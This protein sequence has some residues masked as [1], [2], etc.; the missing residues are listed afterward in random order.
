MEFTALSETLAVNSS[1]LELLLT[2]QLHPEDDVQVFIACSVVP[3][4]NVAGRGAV[5]TNISDG[6]ALLLQPGPYS[7]DDVARAQL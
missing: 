5:Q 4:Q 1:Y 2:G 7:D 6:D 3:D